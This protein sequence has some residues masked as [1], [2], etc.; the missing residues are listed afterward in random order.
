MSKPTENNLINELEQP[1]RAIVKMLKKE[2][3][4]ILLAGNTGVV[5]NPN[6]TLKNNYWF[7]FEFVGGRKGGI[8]PKSKS[9]QRSR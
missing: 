4:T 8:A 1:R 9:I 5:N 6:N 3:W 2:G 7:I